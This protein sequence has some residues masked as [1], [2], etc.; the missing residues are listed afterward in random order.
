VYHGTTRRRAQRI[1]REGF[2]P[3]KPSRRVWFAAGRGYALGRARTQ[4]R[5]SHDRPVVLA[6]ELDLNQLRHSLGK[7]R[8]RATNGIIAIDGP[9]PVTVLRSNPTV[10][11]PFA[12]N[13]LATWINQVLGL[14]PHKG[15]GRSHP[16]IERLSRWLRNRLESEPDR[17]VRPGELLHLARQWLGEYFEGVEVDVEHLCTRVKVGTIDV[18]AEAPEAPPDTREQEA[19]DLLDDGNPKRRIRGLALLARIE[20]PDLFD[21]CLMYLGDQSVDVRIA[22]LDTMCGCEHGDPE[23]IVPLAGSGNKRIRAA[24]VAVLARHSG[25]YAPLWLEYGLTDPSACVRLKTAS[26]LE[27]LDTAEHRK[28]FELALHDPNPTIAR[29]ARKLTAGKGY[30]KDSSRGA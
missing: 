15:V 30:A 23:A 14:K 16:G 11:L 18:R 29:S 2:L 24:A 4:A 10:D 17:T 19:L 13:E 25:K 20:D 26:L 5:R 3:R 1:A 7:K 22:A 8:V 12:P 28:V 6:C 9:V 21:W 27:R